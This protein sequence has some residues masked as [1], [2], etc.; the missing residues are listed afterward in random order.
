MFKSIG[1]YTCRIQIGRQMN[2]ADKRAKQIYI[3]RV[4]SLV[5]ADLYFLKNIWFSDESHLDGYINRQTNRFLE[6]ERRHVIIHKPLHCIFE[7]PSELLYLV[8]E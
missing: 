3:G 2:V 4:L 5:Y 6:F 8:M 7:L 1:G